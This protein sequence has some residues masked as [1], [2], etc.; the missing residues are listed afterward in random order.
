MQ[1]ISSIP[2]P[3]PQHVPRIAPAAEPLS[4]ALAERMARL[5]P[6]GMAIPQLFLTVARNEGLFLH[7]VDTGLIGPTGLLDRKVLS[8]AL[9][10]LVI[11]RT[12]VAAGC[13]YEFNLHVQTI[14]ARM[15]LTAAQIADVGRK[16]ID[17]TLWTPAQRTAI[18]LTDALVQRRP[19]SDADYAAICAQH[20]EPTMLEI[21]FLA[22]LYNTVAMVAALA[23][24]RWDHY[25]R[26][27]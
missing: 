8:P 6:P 5:L 14:S 12:C 22:G 10:E 20:D 4:A 19:I 13:G 7:L 3:S 23:Q 26:R 21:S 27:A 2:A 1:P 11:L 16:D 9:R 15:G 24:P 18:A 17:E 25:R